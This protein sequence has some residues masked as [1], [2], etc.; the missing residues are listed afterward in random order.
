M[1]Y[2]EWCERL[3]RCIETYNKQVEI[4]E[5]SPEYAGL[6]ETI[7]RLRKRLAL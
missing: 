2:R 3:N 1:S 4:K 5:K 6:K 7:E